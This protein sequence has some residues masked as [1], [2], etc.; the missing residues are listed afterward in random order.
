MFGDWDKKIGNPILWDDGETGSDKKVM[1][2]DVLSKVGD[3]FPYEYDLGDSW[4]HTI[5]L[6]KIDDSK[7]KNTRCIAGARSAPP[8]DCGGIHGYH[9]LINHLRHPEKDGYI[10]LLEW[11]SDD[12]DP[13]KFD[14]KLV[15]RGLKGLAKYIKEFDEENGLES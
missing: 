3:T 15:N 12:Y 13:E 10:E 6:E 1:I 5:V 14:L 2:K 7:S 9:E 11:L 4:K 8:E